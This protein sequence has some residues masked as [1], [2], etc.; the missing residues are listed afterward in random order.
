LARTA[1]DG[2][3]HSGIVIDIRDALIDAAEVASLGRGVGR[4]RSCLAL[5]PQEHTGTSA[6]ATAR[7]SSIVIVGVPC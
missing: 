2:V 5:T 6:A 4:L 3:D 1:L 7:D